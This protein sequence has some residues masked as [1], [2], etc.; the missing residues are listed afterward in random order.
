MA[1]KSHM[2]VVLILKAESQKINLHSWVFDSSR[3]E[4]HVSHWPLE[5]QSISWPLRLQVFLFYL[6]ATTNNAFITTSSKMG[7]ALELTI[8]KRP[9]LV[10]PCSDYGPISD[11]MV[12]NTGATLVLAK[13]R[14]KSLCS[15]HPNMRT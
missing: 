15:L 12:F 6:D 11:R 7:R 2:D 4:D 1:N 5:Q 3:P 8:Y 9:R 13:A 10:A 14:V